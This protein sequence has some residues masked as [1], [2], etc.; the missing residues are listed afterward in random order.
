MWAFVQQVKINNL[1]MILVFLILI[2]K[3]VVQDIIHIREI[4]LVLELI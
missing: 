2:L 1:L 3:I 4:V